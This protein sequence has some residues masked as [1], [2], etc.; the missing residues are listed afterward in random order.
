MEHGRVARIVV[1]LGLALGLAILAAHPWVKALEKRLGITMLVSA[2]LPFLAMG[3]IFRREDVGILTP[4]VLDDL[5]PAFVFG[6]GWIGFVIGMHFDMRRIDRL[7]ADL[8][9]VIAIESAVPMV[10]TAV[11]CGIALVGLGVPWNNAEFARDA[12]VLAGCAAPS[13]PA[14]FE[15]LSRKMGGRAARLVEQITMLD[16]IAALLMLGVV[17]IYFRPQGDVLWKLPAIAWFLVSLGLGGVLGIVTYVLIRGAKTEAEELALLLGAV[18]LSAGMAGYLALSVPVV[19]AIAGALLANL[20]MRDAD[21]FKR[22]LMD[23][24]RP[25]YLIFLIV[26]GA[27]WRPS[28]WQGWILAPTFVFARIIGKR[29][30]AIWAKRVGPRDLPSIGNLSLS[31]AP[32]SPV[33]IV[34]IVAAATL[35]RNSNVDRVRWSI[36]AVIMGA[37]LTEVVVRILERLV[38]GKIEPEGTTEVAPSSLRPGSFAE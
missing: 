17:A 9:T 22:I 30:A 38:G 26:V 3:A 14:S 21:G 8:G 32:Q 29:L 18:S 7:P 24:E 27:S 6:L 25:L 1:G 34:A 23:V 36:N 31:L 5:R 19:C 35:F 16:E 12:L 11:L 4:V 13:A 2:G 33:S 37:V 10:T 15:F 28:E 20:P